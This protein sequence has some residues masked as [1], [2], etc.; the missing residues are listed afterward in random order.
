MRE[1]TDI[2]MN[3]LDVECENRMIMHKISVY[4]EFSEPVSYKKAEQYVTECIWRG[5]RELEHDKLPKQ[6]ADEPRRSR[7]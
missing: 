1:P 7:G 2:E 6:A 3:S 4:I 5:Y